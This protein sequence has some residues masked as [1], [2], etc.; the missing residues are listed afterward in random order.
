MSKEFRHKYPTKR[1]YTKY[2]LAE[3]TVNEVFEKFD[4]PA[5]NLTD[6]ATAANIP[7]QT[8]QQW[9]AKYRKDKYYRPGKLIGKHR[10]YFTEQQEEDIATYIRDNYINPGRAVKRK[11]LRLII[12]RCWQQQDITNRSSTILTKKM[13]TYKFL[14]NFCKRHHL[15][16]RTIRG[17]K[18]SDV[19]ESEVGNFRLKRQ[20][21][22]D[23][24][25]RN[26]IANMDETSW[27]FVFARGHVLAECGTEEV[28]ATLP[29]DKR[30]S[31]TTIATILA[32]GS[33][34]KPLFLAQGKTSRCHQQFA[35]MV[36]ETDLFE[37]FHSPG[38]NTDDEVMEYYL[39]LFHGWMNKEPS[40]LFLD[41]YTSHISES[42]KRI[43]DELQITL[44]FIPRSAT[45][46]Y[47]PLDRVIFGVLKSSAAAE[48]DEKFFADD[49]AF[50]KSEAADLFVRL[51]YKLRQSTVLSAWTKTSFEEEEEGEEESMSNSSSS[52]VF[53]SSAESSSCIS[54]EEIE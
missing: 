16:F 38:K 30:A 12:F 24:F 46:M 33:K 27:H 18:R 36:S 11:H 32:D 15:S 51:W 7:F 19:S 48:Y 14:N 23:S 37:V 13:F 3:D 54:D 6:I 9:F 41:Q 31:F 49:A 26:R 39:R 45:E 2:H 21:I 1:K 4:D 40:A 5:W 35:D 10:R 43:A 44:V 20:E 47:Q 28:A 53:S 29:E 52:S 42:T 8:I 50:T 25:P 34:C 17:K 22:F